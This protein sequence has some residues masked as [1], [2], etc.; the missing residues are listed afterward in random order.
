MS[1]LR[2]GSI[3]AG[4]NGTPVLKGV[5]L[6]VGA[7][8]WVALIGP[9]GAGKSTLIG[10][11]G[12][13]VAGTGTVTVADRSVSEMSSR[14][15]SRTVAVVPQEPVIPGGMTVLDYVLLGRTPFISYWGAE[16]AHDV[17]VASE[18]MERVD[19]AGF[20]DRHLGA[21]SGG[22]RQRAVLARAL[23]QEAG[24]LLLDEPTASLDLGHQQQVLDH[25]DQ[26][27][28]EHGI[29][30]VSAVHDLTLAAQYAD[31]LALLDQGRITSEGVPASVLTVENLTKHYGASVSILQDEDG[32]L[33]VAPRRGRAVLP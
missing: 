14:E 5:D 9:N 7:G 1:D 10:V 21:L 26:L 15:R 30:V 31:R 12:Q 4:Y 32:R 3:V 23:A 13:T 24:V 18:I 17:Q 25:V 19:L 8:E 20:E 16:S 28:S 6:V 27:R 22:E 33:V 11:I 29:A 2:C